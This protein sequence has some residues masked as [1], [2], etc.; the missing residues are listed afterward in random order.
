VGLIGTT[1]A[2]RE[3]GERRRMRRAKLNG[4]LVEAVTLDDGLR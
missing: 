3:I 2:A 4:G 1:E